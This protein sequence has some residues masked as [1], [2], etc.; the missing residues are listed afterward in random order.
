M[1]KE[2]FLQEVCYKV[3]YGKELILSSFL[4]SCIFLL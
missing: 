3:I 4:F 1:W 2:R